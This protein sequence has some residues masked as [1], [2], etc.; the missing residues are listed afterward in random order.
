MRKL[1]ILISSIG[2][3][4]I[5]IL[6]TPPEDVI[7][8]RYEKSDYIFSGELVRQSASTMPNYVKDQNASIVK[9]DRV[10]KASEGHEN[11][12]GRE[13]TVLLNR[14][15]QAKME[16]GFSGIF[17]TKTWLFG[18]SLAV[19][20]NDVDADTSKIDQVQKEIKQAK[21]DED[22]RALEARVK[23]A[24]LIVSGKI[25][26]IEN[27]EVKRKTKISEHDPLYMKATII[28]NEILKG[29][30][31]GDRITFYFASSTDVQWYRAPKFTPNEEGIFLLKMNADVQGQK[32][33]YTLL[34]PLDFQESSKLEAI[35]KILK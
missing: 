14:E 32:E 20:M 2:M 11:F 7:I 9:V 29:N 19:L 5:A 15:Q 24:N 22:N 12:E 1:I 23:G 6:C 28:K 13:I 4:F 27:L 25:E 17:F 21:Q 3:I 31:Q 18:N 33:V 8:N 34:N 35:K 26:K 16:R 30:V 10:L